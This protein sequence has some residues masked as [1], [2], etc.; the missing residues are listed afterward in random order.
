MTSKTPATEKAGAHTPTAELQLLEPT[1]NLLRPLERRFVSEY[2]VDLNGTQAMLRA[3]PDVGYESAMA[4][5]YQMMQRPRVQMEVQR[6]MDER[7]L[8]TGITADRVLVHAWQIATADARELTEIIVGSCRHCWGMYNQYQ[9]TD[10]EF[11]ASQDKHIREQTAKRKKDDSYEMKAFAEKGGAG[12]DPSR[13]PNPECPECWGDGQER[14]KI[15]D[16]RKLSPGAAALFSGVKRDKHGN[17]SVMIQDRMAY[18][19]LV[20]RHLGMDKH[21]LLGDVDNPLFVLIQQIQT[22][23]STLPVVATDP[24]AIDVEA[25]EAINKPDPDHREPPAP[26]GKPAPS[27]V[28]AWR[29]K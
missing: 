13:P 4:M 18:L 8:A 2:L 14:L 3:N 28:S 27:A 16:T 22:Q 1:G 19:Q 9:Y 5:A 15:H 29:A 10:A 25:I 20:A 17:L 21:K 11:E 12:Y 7:A 24:E 26:R 23:H 6:L